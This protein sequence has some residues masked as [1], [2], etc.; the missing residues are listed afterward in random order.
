MVVQETMPGRAILS[1]KV[2]KE[3]LNGHAVCHG[4]VIF[5]LA[6]SALAVAQDPLNPICSSSTCSID[7]L[8]PAKGGDVLTA[9]AMEIES[10]GGHI[11]YDVKVT[12]QLGDMVALCRGRT[13]GMGRR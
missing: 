4:G 7:F 6:T 8:S 9:R 5:T 2:R 3:M 10:A 13:A 1:M 11:V 12:N